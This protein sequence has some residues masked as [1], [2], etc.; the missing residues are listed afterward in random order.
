MIPAEGPAATVMMP[1][2]IAMNAK[3]II[4]PSIYDFSVSRDG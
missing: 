1:A 4:H 3:T 2:N